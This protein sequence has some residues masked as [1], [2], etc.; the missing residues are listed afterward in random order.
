[1]SQCD[2][3]Q[4][5]RIFTPSVASALSGFS[6]SGEAEV[7]GPDRFCHTLFQVCHL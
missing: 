3:E 6:D 7:K 4:P 2:D 1:V 5:T